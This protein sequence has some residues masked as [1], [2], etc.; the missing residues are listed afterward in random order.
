[1]NNEIFSKLI[2][3]VFRVNVNEQDVVGQTA[4]HRAAGQGHMQ[5]VT[6][7]LS[8]DNC[9]VD[10]QDRYVNISCFPVKLSRFRTY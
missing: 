8:A 5:S 2:F 3:F 6:A 4:L 9:L 1:M 10:V 7:L